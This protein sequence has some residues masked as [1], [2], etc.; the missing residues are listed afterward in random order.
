VGNWGLGAAD[1]PQA[2]PVGSPVVHRGRAHHYRYKRR[3]VRAVTGAL[4]NKSRHPRS[5]A[6]KTVTL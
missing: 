4:H 5:A 2:R 3:L 6:K 1:C